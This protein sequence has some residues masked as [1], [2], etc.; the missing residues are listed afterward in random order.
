MLSA[1]DDEESKADNEEVKE[2]KNKENK[3]SKAIFNYK[4]ASSTLLQAE[5]TENN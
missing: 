5:K 1:Y 4:R 2:P 3:V